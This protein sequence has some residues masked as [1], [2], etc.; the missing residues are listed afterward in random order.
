MIDCPPP[1]TVT[2]IE[3]EAAGLAEATLEVLLGPLD[4]LREQLT[5]ITGVGLE[6]EVPEGEGPRRRRLAADQP[7]PTLSYLV[8]GRPGDRHV[9]FIHGSPGLAEEWAPY[10]AAT[11]AGQ[12][13]LAVDRPGFGDSPPEDHLDGLEAQARAIAPLLLPPEAGG[14]VVVGYSYGGPLALRLAVDHPEA[15][16]GLVL[17]GSAADPAREETNP[18]QTLAANDFFAG[19]LPSELANA[20][21]ELLALPPEL[22]DLADGLATIRVP[23]ALVQGLEDALVPPANTSYILRHL[24]PATPTRVYLIEDG[25]HFLPW[26][27]SDV[28][29]QALACVLADAGQPSGSAGSSASAGAP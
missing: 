14:T 1:H 8:A 22:H 20:N 29:E 24:P 16:A 9:L 27:H 26:T 3:R 23:V 5:A 2:V 21:T 11:P 25:D 15:V 6:T 4:P 19:L 28:L 17:V 12:Y 7:G 13:R 18:L 10:L